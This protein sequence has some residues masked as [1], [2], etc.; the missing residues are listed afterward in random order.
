MG[1]SRV[2]L[3]LVPAPELTSHL[4]LQQLAPRD[5]S[6]VAVSPPLSRT[7]PPLSAM[8]PAAS[9]SDLP[10]NIKER[11]VELCHADNPPTAARKGTSY[12][13]RDDSEYGG[14]C[15]YGDGYDDYGDEDDYGDAAG[16]EDDYARDDGYTPRYD[17]HDESES[18]SRDG[19][20]DSTIAALFEVSKEWRSIAAPYRFRVRAVVLVRFHQRAFE[21]TLAAFRR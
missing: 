7:G 4:S 3:V 18:G 12:E 5:S 11:I 9:L 15:G 10:R 21:L 19:D 1:H 17:F 8:A 13:G 16:G 20:E 6:A 2:S 14:D